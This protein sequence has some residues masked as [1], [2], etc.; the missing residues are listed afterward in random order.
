MAL[1]RNEDVQWYLATRKDCKRHMVVNENYIDNYDTEFERIREYDS[2]EEANEALAFRIEAD[3]ISNPKVE[4][5]RIKV[6]KIR[7]DIR[8]GN[9]DEERL[10]AQIRKEMELEGAISLTEA[11]PEAAPEKTT[12]PTKKVLS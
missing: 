6:S 11:A 10:R 1:L 2:L 9:I 12:R 4:K 3:A 8:K 5:A 7:G